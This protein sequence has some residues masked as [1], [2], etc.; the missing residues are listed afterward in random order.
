M[1][2]FL[3]LEN[4]HHIH[5]DIALMRIMIELLESKRFREFVIS[6]SRFKEG[7]RLV[8]GLG[9]IMNVFTH[10]YQYEYTRFLSPGSETSSTTVESN[11][12]SGLQVVVADSLRPFTTVDSTLPTDIFHV[13]HAGSNL[14]AEQ[15]AKSKDNDSPSSTAPSSDLAEPE[16]DVPELVND[17]TPITEEDKKSLTEIRTRLTNAVWEMSGMPE[18]SRKYRPRSRLMMELSKWLGQSEWQMQTFAC[19]VLH[20]FLAPEA[21][22]IEFIQNRARNDVLNR[23]KAIIEGPSKDNSV[24]EALALLEVLS[25]PKANKD[26]IF[27]ELGML[28]ALFFRVKFLGS[29]PVQYGAV[30]V[31][32]QLLRGS[33]S[34]IQHFLEISGPPPRETIHIRN[35]LDSY[36][37]FE[38]MPARMEIAQMIVDIFRTAY[39][40]A[41]TG[42][43]RQG[44][45]I[46]M[47][48]RHAK[49][50]PCSIA[51][52]VTALITESRNQALVTQGWFA[53]NLMAR[54]LDGCDAV[55]S[56]LCV[57]A[58]VG[59]LQQIIADQE[60]TSHDRENTRGLAY[61][62]N[63][64]LVS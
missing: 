54:T 61:Q 49:N 14:F 13:D 64:V 15:M 10:T 29:P 53:L 42:E 59:K 1:M 8:D 5:R 16:G 62:M 50:A 47:T 48:L 18:F 6:S 21:A 3:V 19:T 2:A 35:L 36:T 40:A 27:D 20:G 52:P 44:R 28:D 37:K 9:M 4:K 34:N 26:V 32:R 58:D 7:G 31:I 11:P 25:R 60:K 57:G 55:C 30:K 45:I 24:V 63:Q 38:Y 17:Q 23:L 39:S 41:E 56:V 33:Y 43:T 12:D 46:E 22:S 51:T